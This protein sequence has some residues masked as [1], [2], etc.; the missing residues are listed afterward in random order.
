MNIS[1]LLQLQNEGFIIGS[2][3][4]NHAEFQQ[5]SFEEMKDQIE[6]GFRLL[7]THLNLK[8]RAFSFPFHDI[9]IP[10]TFFDYL[11]NEAKVEIS[12]GTSGIKL[13]EAQGHIHRIP[14]ELSGFNGAE[15][16]I[17]SEYFYYIGKSL[18]G[19]NLVKRR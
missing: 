6:S 10:R 17:R 3:S 16:I 13:D 5:L 7:E 8:H 14:M 2:H 11:L 19:K 1:E 15:A 12:F 9:G 4:L 18:F